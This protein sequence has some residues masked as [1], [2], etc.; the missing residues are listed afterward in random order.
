MYETALRAQ[1]SSPDTF[2]CTPGLAK[3]FCA[4]VATNADSG[5]TAARPSLTIW[6]SVITQR[7]LEV[8]SEVVTSADVDHRISTFAAETAP[9]EVQQAL[10]HIF[11]VDY[12]DVAPQFFLQS[13]R[14]Q[15][16]LEWLIG[17]VGRLKAAHLPLEWYVPPAGEQSAAPQRA[18][19]L[20]S[21]QVDRTSPWA[22]PYSELVTLLSVPSKATAAL[23]AWAAAEG[24]AGPQ[25]LYRA[26]AL[27]VVAG[28]C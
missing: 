1:V 24:A 23:A 8:L 20:M 27:L 5:R 13:I 19:G 2:G 18:F 25:R 11:E 6:S 4:S 7:L 22:E 9:G 16:A 26:R 14:K 15:P 17:D 3:L 21:F 12:P 28:G 10:A